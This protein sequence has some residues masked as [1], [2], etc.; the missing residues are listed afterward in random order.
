MS[1]IT[2]LNVSLKRHNTRKRHST[3]SSLILLSQWSQRSYGYATHM[4]RETCTHPN[5]PSQEIERKHQLS[6]ALTQRKR[7]SRLLLRQS[8]KEEAEAAARKIAEDE[9][10]NSRAKRLAARLKKEEE[11]RERRET[12]REMRRREREEREQ[13]ERE[14]KT[15]TAGADGDARYA[16]YTIS[17]QLVSMFFSQL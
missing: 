6:L 15:K 5:L 16:A 13:K 2:L 17:F 11:E 14:G 3:K 7:S 8:E 4:F 10:K 9:E 12:S 1:G